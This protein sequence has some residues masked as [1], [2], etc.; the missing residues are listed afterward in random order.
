M[1]FIMAEYVKFKEEGDG[2][3]DKPKKNKKMR[4]RFGFKTII[5]L[6]IL[7]FIISSII[8]GIAYSLTPKIAVVKIGGT[9]MTEEVSSI[10]GSSSISS[11]EIAGILKTLESDPSIKAV[12]LDIN[13]PGGSPVASEEI[14]RAVES[15]KESKPVYALVND[16]G[17]SGAFWVAVSADKV[18]ASSMSTLGSIGVTS[19]SLGFE[20]LIEQYNVSYRRL[21][22]GEYKDMGTPFRG[23]TDDE[24]D[25]IQE[26]LDEVH[27]NF[28]N[29]VATSRNM[30]Y[31][32]VEQYAEGQIFLGTKAKEIGFID[33]IGYYPDVI[34]DL[35][36]MTGDVLVED[37][38][39][40]PSIWDELGVTGLFNFG[41]NINS[42][43]QIL[44]K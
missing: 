35:K 20:E 28:I 40:T 27:S 10:Y 33:E 1:N 4:L 3:D 21:V 7:F 29:H 25:M 15:I 18:Y 32:D 19:A 23:L 42:K 44:L 43:N 41:S 37:F 14:S 6:V 13:S 11:R 17:A 36:N 8:S 9:I 16:V 12:V 39:P 5:L 2:D 22:A 30:S 38:G 34:S 26:I 31:E 24:E